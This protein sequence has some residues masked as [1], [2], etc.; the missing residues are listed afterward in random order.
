MLLGINTPINKIDSSVII[1][2]PGLSN[3]LHTFLAV[4]PVHILSSRR[5]G[6]G[7]GLGLL[8]PVIV[9]GIALGLVQPVRGRHGGQGEGDREGV[10][11]HQILI[12][13]TAGTHWS[14]QQ[15][16]GLLPGRVALAG[17][18]RSGGRIGIRNLELGWHK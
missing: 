13:P 7:S 9:L 11:L 4:P 15:C 3:L 10:W 12:H 6:S 1:S 2:S 18:D 14:Y 16:P 5:L 17:Q 8:G